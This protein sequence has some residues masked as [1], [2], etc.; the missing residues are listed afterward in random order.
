MS[1]SPLSDKCEVDPH[2]TTATRK[3]PAKGTT[4]STLSPPPRAAT[5]GGGG[6]EDPRARA[7]F[8]A[9]P[10]ALTPA[11]RSSKQAGTSANRNPSEGASGADSAPPSPMGRRR[12]DMIQFGPARRVGRASG[13]T[14]SYRIGE[15]L[16][17]AGRAG[18]DPRLPPK[19][20]AGRTVALRGKPKCVRSLAGLRA[21]AA[22]WQGRS[23]ALRRRCPSRVSYGLGVVFDPH[24]ARNG[25]TLTSHVFALRSITSDSTPSPQLPSRDRERPTWEVLH[26]RAVGVARPRVGT[27]A[28]RE[29]CK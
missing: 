1:N 18:D 17:S 9:T 2:S 4:G 3:W 5:K 6:E 21:G 16:R 22:G 10:V 7:A 25:I 8:H 27:G 29:Y 19:S 12:R 28:E 23:R 13:T 15:A 11:C 20:S 24:R 14:T 26:E